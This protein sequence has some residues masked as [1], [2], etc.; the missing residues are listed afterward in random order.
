MKRNP[1]HIQT[2]GVYANPVESAD[3]QWSIPVEVALANCREWRR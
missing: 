2:D 1:V 3:G